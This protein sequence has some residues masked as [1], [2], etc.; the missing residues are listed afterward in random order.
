MPDPKRYTVRDPES[1]RTVTFAWSGDAP[2][3]DDDMAEVFASMPPEPKL[4]RE[5][6]A[7]PSDA[8]REQVSPFGQMLGEAGETVGR[9][10]ND[11]LPA[12]LSTGAALMTGG[13]SL[14][15][16]AGAGLLAGMAGSA[17]RETMRRA[18]GEGKPL[19]SEELGLDMAKE[20][21]ISGG[22]AAARVPLAAGR[23]VAP[24]IAKNAARFGN[25]AKAAQ[26]VLGGGLGAA[27]MSGN[28]PAMLTTGT[29]AIA[30]DPRV[31]RGVGNLVGRVG[32]SPM[33]NAAAGR[34]G[35]G[36]NTA[37]AGADAFRQAL[38]DALGED[39]A[40]TVP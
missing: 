36:A 24:V 32:S 28:V 40:S 30:T 8:A 23:A 35:L 14:P 21:A 2:P 12:I 37:R 27:A 6:G 16:T 34:L 26:T 19:T 29:A 39:P 9:F 33:L 4:T 38:L 22:L 31:I 1:G 13:A 10:S 11:N 25:A 3:T 17:G 15:V 20:G 18:V 5:R 7:P